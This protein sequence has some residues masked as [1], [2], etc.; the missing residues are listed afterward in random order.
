MDEQEQNIGPAMGKLTDLQRRWV[1]ALVERGGNPTEA[2]RLAGY[3][4][5][6]ANKLAQDNACA[7]AGHSN[8]RSPKV[9][10]AIR[11]EAG[12]RLYS[13]ALIGATVL[14]EIANDPAHKDRLKAAKLLL[15]HNGYQIIAET[16]IKV[17][18]VSTDNKAVIAKIVELAAKL[19]MD[20]Q[21]L[22]GQ[23]GVT[24]DAEFKVVEDARVPTTAGLED[25]L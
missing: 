10:D 17:T 19:D 6:A 14:M 7:V 25:I 16:N 21:K 1:Y 3:G 9:Q 8:A 23:Y 20:P 2:A 22:L 5:N 13:G 12:H 4:A 11:E 18:H 15:E 24:V